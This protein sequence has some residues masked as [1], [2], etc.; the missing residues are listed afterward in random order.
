MHIYI[1]IPT[2]VIYRYSG[3]RKYVA[4]EHNIRMLHRPLRV[5]AVAERSACLI[6]SSGGGGGGGGGSFAKAGGEDIIY[7]P[8]SMLPPLLQLTPTRAPGCEVFVQP[9]A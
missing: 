4:V 3:R 7:D 9:R 8:L 1:Y 2:G 5:R 6:S